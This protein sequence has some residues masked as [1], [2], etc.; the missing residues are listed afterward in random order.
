MEPI[1]RDTACILAALCVLLLGGCWNGRLLFS[2]EMPFWSSLGNDSG[3]KAALSRDAVRRGYV[4]RFDI[5]GG[6]D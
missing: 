5:G 3:L 1:P 2:F 6:S 4:P